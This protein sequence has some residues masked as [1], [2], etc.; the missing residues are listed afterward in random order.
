[1]E[2]PLDGALRDAQHRR[3]LLDGPALPVV[4]DQDGAQ[5][6]RQALE[7]ALQLIEV[8]RFVGDAGAAAGG[9]VRLGDEADGD[10]VDG[11]A[12][13]PAPGGPAGVEVDPPEPGVEPLRVAQLADVAPGVEQGVLGGV[14]RVGLAAQDREGG[15]EGGL[16]PAIHES[17]EGDPVALARPPDE[18][19]PGR[20]LWREDWRGQDPH[21]RRERFVANRD[22]G[23]AAAVVVARSSVDCRIAPTWCLH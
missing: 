20:E 19:D 15:P 13:A 16:D 3:D 11:R 9:L 17:L 8:G 7:G 1:M 10:L 12:P 23:E 18:V 5:R 14:A 4:Q 21:G 6:E 2:P 22:G